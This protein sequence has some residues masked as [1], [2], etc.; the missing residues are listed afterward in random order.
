MN[1]YRTCTSQRQKRYY[2][3][4]IVCRNIDRRFS[5]RQHSISFYTVNI[6]IFPCGNIKSLHIDIRDESKLEE[7]PIIA[8]NHCDKISLN[9]I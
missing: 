5:I 6:S 4:E 3:N 7:C 9:S 8:I 1:S 2:R